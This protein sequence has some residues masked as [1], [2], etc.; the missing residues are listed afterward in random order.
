VTDLAQLRADVDEMAR[1]GADAADID[2]FL[3]QQG[4]DPRAF[5]GTATATDTMGVPPSSHGLA[6]NVVCRLASGLSFGLAE[7][8]SAGVAAGINGLGGWLRGH[9]KLLCLP[10]QEAYGFPE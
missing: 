7:E 5:H 4:V 8:A 6:D 3:R 10:Q 9:S 2:G 1:M